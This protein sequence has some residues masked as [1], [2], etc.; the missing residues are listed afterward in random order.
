VIG[1][2][3]LLSDIYTGSWNDKWTT[4]LLKRP[5]QPGELRLLRELCPK[6]VIPWEMPDVLLPLLK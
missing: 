1:T 5:L 3:F 4:S 6:T 2:D